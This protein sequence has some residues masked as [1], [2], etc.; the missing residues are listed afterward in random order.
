M[1][2]SDEPGIPS[3][4]EHDLFIRRIW[5]LCAIGA[6]LC[7]VA[8]GGTVVVMGL[9]GYDSKTIANVQLIAVYIVLPAYAIGYVAPALATSLIKMSLGVEMSRR[10]LD[11]GRQTADLLDG[12]SRDTKPIVEDLKNIIAS[13]RELIE[14]LKRQKA[15]KIVEFLEKLSKDGTVDKIAGSLDEIGRKVGEVVRK[16]EQRKVD[17]IIDKI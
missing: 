2:V 11:V 15:G 1:K 9:L 7:L 16:S 17:D 6:T 12:F 4:V 3:R 10:G 5:K 8:M 14:D 13:V